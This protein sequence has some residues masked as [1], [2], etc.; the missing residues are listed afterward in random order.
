MKFNDKA[1]SN[2]FSAYFRLKFSSNIYVKIIALVLLKS[3]FG[4]M[5]NRFL[6]PRIQRGQ[7]CQEF[8]AKHDSA[9]S[10]ISWL[11]PA[12]L[13]RSSRRCLSSPLLWQCIGARGLE[14][15]PSNSSQTTSWGFTII[16]RVMSNKSSI[17][18]A[19]WTVTLRSWQS[20]F[21]Q[22][23]VILSLQRWLKHRCC[24]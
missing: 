17:F 23:L 6:L 12:S 15:S 4:V 7:I 19:W 22:T 2:I 16:L 13:R 5:R 1:W 24:L 21:E 14:Q 9:I 18:E 8:Y 11:S 20:I 10:W 3:I